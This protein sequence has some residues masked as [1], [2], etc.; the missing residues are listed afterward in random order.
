[1]PGILL[2]RR[3][4]WVAN[5]SLLHWQVASSATWEAQLLL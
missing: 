1:M 2:A 4:E 3:L 5:L